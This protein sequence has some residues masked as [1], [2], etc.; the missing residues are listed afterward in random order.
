MWKEHKK[1]I[2]NILIFYLNQ[3]NSIDKSSSKYQHIELQMASFQFQLDK[4]ERVEKLNEQAI[5]ETTIGSE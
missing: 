3:L 4:I 1:W 5:D 2:E